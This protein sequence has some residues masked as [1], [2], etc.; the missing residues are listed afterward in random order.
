MDWNVPLAL[1]DHEVGGER[2]S[3][4]SGIA[5]AMRMALFEAPDGFCSTGTPAGIGLIREGDI[6]RCTIDRLGTLRNPVQYR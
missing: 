3:Q 2:V 6:M 5:I 1:H 4:Q